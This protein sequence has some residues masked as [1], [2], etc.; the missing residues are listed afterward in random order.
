VIGGIEV[1]HTVLKTPFRIAIALGIVVGV[2]FVGMCTGHG[3]GAAAGLAAEN[4]GV[5]VPAITEASS[6][7]DVIEFTQ[8]A[9]HT[10]NRIC[11]TG[12]RASGDVTVPFAAVVDKKTG[13]YVSEY[14]SI[15]TG[16]DA[17]GQY[18]LDG[19]GELHTSPPMERDSVAEIDK[20]DALAALDPSVARSGE[21]L[22]NTPV[23]NWISPYFIRNELMVN[24]QSVKK[25]GL[26]TVAGRSAMELYVRF[27]D[28]LAKED[29]WNLFIDM[30][31]GIVL[32]L[33]A[34]PLP[35]E[36][37]WSIWVES[38]SF[39]DKVADSAFDRPSTVVELQ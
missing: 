39:D 24:A 21:L 33:D 35:G 25:I 10:W 34:E 23:N 4:E 19:L 38:V 18:D 15:T 29:H 17:D 16:S 5:K 26:A 8:T 1:A 2:A 30:E 13:Y 3:A 28:S 9:F 6:V 11:V 12:K 27:P 32:G 31:T 36:S 20:I 22:V 37:P 7:G 14:G